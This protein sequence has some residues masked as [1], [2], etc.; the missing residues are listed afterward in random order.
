MMRPIGIKKERLFDKMTSSQKLADIF[1]LYPDKDF[2]L[3]A[4]AGE[5]GIAKSMASEIIDEMASMGFVKLQ[6]VGAKLWLIRANTENPIFIKWKIFS[7]LKVIYESGI[8]EFLNEQYRN[9]KAVILFGSFRWGRDVMD[10][11]ID[12]AVEVLEDVY[13]IH[14]YPPFSEFE[15]KLHR[16]IQ[17]HLFS[18]KSIDLNLFNNI[19]NGIVL[20]G[21]LEVNK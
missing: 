2:T 19:A 20:S 17:I 11:D 5:A 16:K 18:R 3:S 9:P 13:D 14:K 15:K 1:Y 7:N 6:K 21:F 4:I 10:S 12:I 8:V